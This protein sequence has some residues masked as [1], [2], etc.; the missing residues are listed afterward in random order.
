MFTTVAVAVAAAGALLLAGCGSTTSTAPTEAASATQASSTAPAPLAPASS[1][2]AEATTEPVLAKWTCAK[3]GEQVTCTCVGSEADCKST[4]TKPGTLKG[5]NEKGSVKWFSGSKGYGFIA[6]ATGEDVF[7][8]FSAI[9]MGGVTTLNPDECVEFE[10][11]SGPK[12]LQAE[13]VRVVA[14]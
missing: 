6:R 1:S 3:D 11:K 9:E 13:G 8:H 5:F 12:A 7:V 4:V 2:P 14:C 10:V